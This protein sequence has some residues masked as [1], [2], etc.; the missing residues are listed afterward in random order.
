VAEPVSLEQQ[1]LIL[2]G[3]QRFCTQ[4][5]K[6]DKTRRVLE[7]AFGEQWAERYMNTV[8][9]DLPETEVSSSP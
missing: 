7:K 9:F 2:A 8:L 6:N 4:Q 3:Q 1:K 5:Q